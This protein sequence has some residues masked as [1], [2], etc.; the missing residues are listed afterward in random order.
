METNAHLSY[1]ESIAGMKIRLFMEAI[2]PKSYFGKNAH[3]FHLE[4]L[5][6]II[7]RFLGK[8][9][10]KPSKASRSQGSKLHTAAKQGGARSS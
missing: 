3:L 10:W 8:D 6:G 5:A 2:T 7:P 9:Y 4:S 1:L